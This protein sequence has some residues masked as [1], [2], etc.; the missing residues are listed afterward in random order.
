MRLT[1]AQRK[2]LTTEATEIG[3]NL[4]ALRQRVQNMDVG[5]DMDQAT[6]IVRVRQHIMEATAGIVTYLWGV[7]CSETKAEG[8]DK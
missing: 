8:D 6:R 1:E 5:D 2:W 3:R 4:E 7:R